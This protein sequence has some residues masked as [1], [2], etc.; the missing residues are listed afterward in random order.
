MFQ[1]FHKIKFVFIAL[2]G[3]TWVHAIEID[4]SMTSLNGIVDLSNIEKAF[5]ICEENNL[6]GVFK[7]KIYDRVVAGIDVLCGSDETCKENTMKNLNALYGTEENLKQAMKSFFRR[8]N[9]EVLHSKCESDCMELNIFPGITD[10]SEMY[11]EVYSAVA[12]KSKTCQ[13][14]IIHNLIG[15]LARHKI[16]K[17]CLK[18]EDPVCQKLLKDLDILRER[19]LNL[20][21]LVYGRENVEEWGRKAEAGSVCMDCEG[22]DEAGSAQDR[23]KNMI[24]IINTS[25][26][27]E[28]LPGA[29][30]T[31]IA[32]TDEKINPS[33]KI[34][35]EKD[36]SYSVFLNLEFFADVD[37]DG[38]APAED[39]PSHYMKKAQTC[40]KQ[41]GEKMLGPNGEK[42][43]ILVSTPSVS[44][45]QN[46][47]PSIRAIAIKK[48]GFRPNSAEYSG[49]I[50]C[51]AITHEI[52][53]LL[54]LPDE[55]QESSKGYYV[56]PHTGQVENNIQKVQAN[57]Q[58]YQFLNAFDCRIVKEN[59][60]MGSHLEKWTHVFEHGEDHSLLN[61]EH[62]SSIIYGG[63]PE[64]NQIFNQC[65]RLSQKSSVDF[66]ECLEQKRQCEQKMKM[67]QQ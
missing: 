29:E 59:S 65:A 54:G 22:A 6:S 41:A 57:P 21:R 48:K 40:L 23:V 45:G 28:I 55:Y 30:R 51:P 43:Q 18:G 67:Q 38:E 62:F 4:T 47:K 3:L 53:H 24:H 9:R 34:K 17:K 61:P 60:L 8:Y 36:G 35:R 64:K 46:C 66:P 58:T 42:L 49:D 20:V 12:E 19:V 1:S 11:Q 39:V 14:N 10:T 26:C 44:K 25:Q 63:C 33:Y 52:L 13:E 31:V 27:Q 7:K 15:E 16:P 37:Y 2:C 56:D 32:G 5:K 50:D